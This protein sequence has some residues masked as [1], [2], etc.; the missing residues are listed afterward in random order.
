MEV[1]EIRTI[2]K[3]ARN[4]KIDPNLK[5]ALNGFVV[6]R[7]LLFRKLFELMFGISC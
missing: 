1:M 4:I 3:I 2:G 6:F 5:Q 7:F